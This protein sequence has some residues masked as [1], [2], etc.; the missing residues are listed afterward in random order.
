MAKANNIPASVSLPLTRK[1]VDPAISAATIRLNCW[2][3]I[4]CTTGNVPNTNTTTT[5]AGTHDSRKPITWSHKSTLSA[6]KP[7]SSQ[8]N[9]TCTSEKG[10][11]TLGASKN[12]TYTGYANAC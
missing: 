12:A 7:A 4:P 11:L 10:S 6:V 5:V 2:S 9:R 8:R 1:N 3:L